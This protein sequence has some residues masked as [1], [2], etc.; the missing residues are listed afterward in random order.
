MK[1]NPPVNHLFIGTSW[2]LVSQMITKILEYSKYKH[3]FIVISNA[4]DLTKQYQDFFCTLQY[5]NYDII[6]NYSMTGLKKIQSYYMLLKNHVFLPYNSLKYYFCLIEYLRNNPISNLI[7]HFEMSGFAPILYKTEYPVVWCCWGGI[8]Q[9]NKKSILKYLRRSYWFKNFIEA[10][11]KVVALTDSDKKMIEQNYNCNGVI[12]LS[13]SYIYNFDSFDLR[14]HEECSNRILI[15]NSAYFLNEYYNI[16][17]KLKTHKGLELTFM[18]SYGRPENEKYIQWKKKIKEILEPN[19]IVIFWEENI[20]LIE[21]NKRLATYGVLI[22]GMQRQSGLGAC[23]TALG[24]GIKVYLNGVNY[25]Y[26]INKKLRVHHIKELEKEEIKQ[27]LSQS[28]EDAVY[29]SKTTRK[30][31]GITQSVRGWETLYDSLLN[32]KDSTSFIS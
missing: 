29:N 24:M 14:K 11:Y 27:L 32:R 22:M 18:C 10:C 3:H 31:C 26:Y 23:T 21:Y 15:G 9:Y 13:Y 20:P 16:A 7:V 12:T 4:K 8:P 2:L 25:A 1:R 5:E 30:V 6:T 19:N 28:N 17:E